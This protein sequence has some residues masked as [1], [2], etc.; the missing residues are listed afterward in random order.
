[1]LLEITTTHQPATDLGYLLHK[2]PEK[3]QTVEL[4]VGQAHIFYPEASAEICTACLLL[5]INPIDLVRGSKS[6]NVFLPEHY[7]ND[8][9]Y[10]ANSFL[11]TAIGKAFGSAINGTCLSR[12]EL[13]VTPIPLKA[14]VHALK[15]DTKGIQ[16]VKE[17]DISVISRLFEPLGYAISCETVP[18]DPQFPSWGDSKSI[19]LTIEKTVTLKELLSHLSIFLMVLDTERHYWISQND[20]EVLMRRGEGWL[21]GHPEKEWITRRYLKNLRELTEPLLGDRVSPALNTKPN[22]HQQRLEKACELLKESGA[23]SVVDMGCGEGKLLKLLLKDGQFQKIRGMDVAFGELQ[24]A[25]GNLYLDEAS[26]AL[27][28]RIGLFQGSITYKDDR[29][30]NFDAAVLVEVIEHLDI[31]RLPTMEHVVF[32]HAKPT[33]VVLSTPNAEYNAV[34]EK[35]DATQF[36]HDDHRF[37]WTRKEFA[38][39]CKHVCEEFSYMVVI[40]PVG[41]ETEDYGTPSQIAVFT[42][43]TKQ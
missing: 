13:V 29:L 17:G 42:K 40:H 26:P 39:W 23:R 7:V 21:D 38:D 4:A 24:K 20:V 11:S 12:P 33:T 30:A 31:D 6:K 5:D 14:T 19:T 37:E 3:L 43:A 1:M 36:R 2:H 10:T 32:G 34:F 41:P 9:P 18:L 15:I 27:R 16:R 28:E 22:L 8:R 25:K 35:L